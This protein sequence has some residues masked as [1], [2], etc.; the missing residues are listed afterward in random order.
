[1]RCFGWRL[2]GRVV[3][4][5]HCGRHD[6]VLCTLCAAVHCRRDTTAHYVLLFTVVETPLHT[7][8]CCLLWYRHDCVLCTVCCCSLAF[9]HWRLLC[10]QVVLVMQQVRGPGVCTLCHLYCPT[11]F[12]GAESAVGLGSHQGCSVRKVRCT[13]FVVLGTGRSLCCVW[14]LEA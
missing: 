9:S 1:M 13:L 4:Y 7:V 3:T 14:G 8:C 6:R 2:V 12:V 10:F 5:V 11:K